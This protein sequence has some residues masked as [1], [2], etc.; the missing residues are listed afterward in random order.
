MSVSIRFDTFPNA[1]DPWLRLDVSLYR[2]SIVSPELTIKVTPRPD[3]N[4]FKRVHFAT[5]LLL[6]SLTAQ[7]L[8]PPRQLQRGLSRPQPGA[9][10]TKDVA[11]CQLSCIA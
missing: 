1:G 5:L 7:R 6:P 3:R 10:I 9:P 11:K 8:V 4:S 2:P